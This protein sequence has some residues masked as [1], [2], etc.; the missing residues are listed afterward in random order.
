VGGRGRTI[1]KRREEGRE[2]K[3]E[4]EAAFGGIIVGRV[5]S[6]RAD[7]LLGQSGQK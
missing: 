1:E 3:R 2:E 6:L 7:L 4:E 5:S